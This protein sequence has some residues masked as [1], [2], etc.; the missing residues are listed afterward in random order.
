MSQILITGGTIIDCT[1]EKPKPRSA[2]LVVDGRIA[3]IG[4]DAEVEGF[5]AQRYPETTI[6]DAAGMTV[7]PGLIDVHVHCSY[8][9][10]V[11]SD[12]LNIL[13]S[14]EYRTLRGA[15]AVRKVLRAGVTSM[16]D[17][18]GTFKVA[19][20]IREMEHL[21]HY[22]GMSSMDALIAGTRNGAFAMGM[23]DEIGTLEVGKRADVVVVDGDPLADITILQDKSR[24]KLIIKDGAIVDT[25]T[26]LPTPR[27]YRWEKSGRMWADS[28]PATQ[29][30]VRNFATSKPAWMR[31]AR[32][33]AAE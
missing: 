29:D 23:E 9:D 17:P 24:L 20:A 4:N 7:M 19:L 31:P 5:A 30:F 1:G 18:G 33:E 13:T 2:I 11:S 28:R 26:P 6:I 27:Q 21:M 16:V 22:L 12:E 8:G 25:K 10:S 14:A 3:K 32:R 15:L